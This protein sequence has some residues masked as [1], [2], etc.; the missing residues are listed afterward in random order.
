VDTDR[1]GPWEPCL[2]LQLSHYPVH[3]VARERASGSKSSERNSKYLHRKS[4]S[5]PLR[6]RHFSTSSSEWLA[7]FDARNLLSL[8]LSNHSL[9]S[10]V[11]GV[12]FSR[13]QSRPIT[14]TG[15][16]RLNADATSN[17]VPFS[18]ATAIAPSHISASRLAVWIGLVG[19][20]RRGGDGP[21]RRRADSH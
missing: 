5:K 14:A 8:L 19:D 13:S 16:C 3:S 4:R 20:V 11:S 2:I 6:R 1:K 9:A 18:P 12:S 21:D 10:Y 7:P 17:L 15:R